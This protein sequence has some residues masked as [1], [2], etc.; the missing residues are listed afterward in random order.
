MDR[1]VRSVVFTFSSRAWTLCSAF[2]FPD[3][4]LVQ[5]MPHQAFCGGR[6]CR[7]SSLK[8]LNLAARIT[9]VQWHCDEI[10][11][12]SAGSRLRQDCDAQIGANKQGKL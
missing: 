8:Q 9:V 12:F 5:E 1:I 3:M 6:E 10:G 11:S 4:K 7:I 2:T